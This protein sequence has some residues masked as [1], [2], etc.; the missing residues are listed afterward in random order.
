MTSTH[1]PR[2]ASSIRAEAE[3]RA[4][5]A[6]LGA[7][8]LEEQWL[9]NRAPHRVR[10]AQGHDCAPQPGNVCRGQGICKTCAGTDPRI[11]EAVFRARLIELGATLIEERWLGV[12]TPHRLLCAQGHA[13][14]PRPVHV[15]WGQGICLTCVDKDPKA[16]EA[17]FRR[18]LAELGATLLEDRW[19]GNNVPHRA[20]CVR[21]HECAP[22]PKGVHRG[23]GI[24]RICVGNIWDAFYV[25]HDE[26]Q[27]VIKVGI[28]SGDPRPRL[29]T[30]ARDGFEEVLRIHSQLPDGVAP[31]LERMVLAAL[32]DVRETPVRG[33]E[34]FPARV[35]PLVLDLVD[36]HPA[37]RS[38]H[39]TFPAAE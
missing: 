34:Y 39:R 17:A 31:E 7:E 26:L 18:R 27:G 36:N 5:L 21:G 6:E 32:R 12:N 14:A 24:C 38:A 37:V 20:L 11:A 13:C 4:R 16:A 30:H 19:L 28:T 35:L 25:V 8:L 3:F 9:G 33:K 10:C 1:K 29:T 22:W 2:R 23:Q 15:R